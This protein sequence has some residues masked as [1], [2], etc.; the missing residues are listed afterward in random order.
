MKL[1]SLRN[2]ALT[3]A[4]SIAGLGLIGVGA[5]AVFT[6]STQSSQT[7]AAGTLDVS[8]SGSSGS[9][10][11]YDN[12]GNCTS[13]GVTVSPSSGFG[14][15]FDSGPIAITLTNTGSLAAW[16]ASQT[17]TVSTTGGTDFASDA[18]VCVWSTGVDGHYQGPNYSGSIA[19]LTVGS[20]A[21]YSLATETGSPAV[22]SIQPT[23][24]DD[25]VVD[26]YAGDGGYTPSAAPA[27]ANCAP[28]TGSLTNVD[29]GQG[30]T[31]TF[32]NTW[33]DV[34]S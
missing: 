9:C 3:G 16:Y 1:F 20:I 13:W 14:S 30:A 5:H 18:S 34:A 32:S 12:I 15:T 2:L 8:S 10:A 22:Y 17:W 7:I 21:S 29:E 19:G 23:Q 31:V 6:T 27:Y 26:F 28:S 33:E 4:L 24:S 25:Y 11:A